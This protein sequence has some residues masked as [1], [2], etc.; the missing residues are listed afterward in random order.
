MMALF[1]E[2]HSGR[3]PLYS[4]NFG[5]IILIPKCREVVTI[6]QYRPICLLS[7]SFKK[8]TKVAMNR[9]TEV[10]KKVISPTQTTFLPGRNTMEDVIVLHKTIH[11]IHRKKQDGVILKIDFEKAYDKIN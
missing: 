9:V 8:F 4:L 7:V 2:F 3:L 5:T 6:Q 11:E 1:M 10:A